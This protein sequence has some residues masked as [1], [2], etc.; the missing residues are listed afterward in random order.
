VKTN[1]SRPGLS[2]IRAPS[3]PKKITGGLELRK[4]G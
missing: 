3:R 2:K 4:L 1:E